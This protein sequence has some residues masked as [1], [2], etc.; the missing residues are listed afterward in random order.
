MQVDKQLK[1]T[2]HLQ[3]NLS[4]MNG[5]MHLLGCKQVHLFAQMPSWCGRRN[6]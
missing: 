3:M 2:G 1:R 6:V 4:R 5:A